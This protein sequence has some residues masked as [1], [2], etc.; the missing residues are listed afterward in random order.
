MAPS[1]LIDQLVR[2]EGE[3]LHAYQDSLGY[4]TIGS[5]ILID[6]RGGGITH[7]ENMYLLQNRAERTAAWV[8]THLPWSLALDD[9]RLAALNNM[10]YNID[11]KLE[12]FVQFLAKLKAG[13]YQGAA[14]EMLNSLWAR[15]VGARAHRLSE[16]IRTGVWI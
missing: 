15:Q 9:V 7:E 1:N 13:D 11:G 16:Q 12:Q 14:E 8:R 10:A 6:A 2:D 3:I 4:W 5:G